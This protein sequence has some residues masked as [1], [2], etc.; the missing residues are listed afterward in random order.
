[1][2]HP[3]TFPAL[4]ARLLQRAAELRS[5]L[6]ATNRS[7]LDF[8]PDQDGEVLDQKDQAAEAS[9][10]AVVQSE[11]D[12]E[13]AELTDIEAA[14]LRLESGGYGQCVDCEEPIDPRRLEAQ[15]AAARCVP[16]QT[17]FERHKSGVG[18]R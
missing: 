9:S 2:T 15:P 3:S 11:S 18:H 10:Y 16:C 14:L 8:A 13:I 6:E 5:E 12:L 4:R 1:M 7:P 17:V